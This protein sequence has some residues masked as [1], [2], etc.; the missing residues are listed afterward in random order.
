[1]RRKQRAK[2]PSNRSSYAHD[3]ERLFEA[4]LKRLVG[5]DR[6]LEIADRFEA[7][8]HLLVDR[9]LRAVSQFASERGFAGSGKSGHQNNHAVGSVAEAEC[10]WR[11]S[12]SR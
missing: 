4:P 11:L 6:R 1:M 7:G 8:F 10:G 9:A 5:R 3:G 2:A 12:W